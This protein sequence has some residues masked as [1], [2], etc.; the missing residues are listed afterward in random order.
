MT[1]EQN[2]AMLEL[3]LDA[4]F[5]DT[6]RTAAKHTVIVLPAPDAKTAYEIKTK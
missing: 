3:E 4:W 5:E 1:P 2:R 6:W